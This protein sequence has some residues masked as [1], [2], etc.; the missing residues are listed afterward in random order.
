M[1]ADFGTRVDALDQQVET[2]KQHLD[3]LFKFAEEVFDGEREL[4]LL[5]TDLSVN[6][7][8]VAFIG[9]YGCERYFKH[10]QDLLLFERKRD[11][12]DRLERGGFEL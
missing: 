5:V 8:S 3:N 2:G 4:L 10:N 7:Y 12:K 6:R 9:E 11:I 1:T